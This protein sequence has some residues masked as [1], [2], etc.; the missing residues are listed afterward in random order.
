MLKEH[1]S[2]VDDY[3]GSHPRREEVRKLFAPSTPSGSETAIDLMT[4]TRA[5]KLHSEGFDDVFREVSSQVSLFSSRKR[6]RRD[7]PEAD[8]FRPFDTQGK[9]VYCL[10]CGRLESV[11]LERL[12]RYALDVSYIPVYRFLDLPSHSFLSPLSRSS[13]TRPPVGASFSTAQQLSAW[14][15]SPFRGYSKL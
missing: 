9:S 14:K 3:L 4:R 2:T 8:R 6:K 11:D 10:D 12:M 1:A 13:K 5:R 15:L 7:E